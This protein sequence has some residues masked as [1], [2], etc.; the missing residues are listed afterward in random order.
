MN[1]ETGDKHE[2]LLWLAPIAGSA[3][4]LEEFALDWTSWAEVTL[5]F[6]GIATLG[7]IAK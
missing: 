3:Y 1:F 7:T 2:V 5:D 4:V 6:S